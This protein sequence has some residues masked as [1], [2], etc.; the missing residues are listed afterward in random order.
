[1]DRKGQILNET[2]KVVNLTDELVA[3]QKTSNALGEEDILTHALGGKDRPRIV[4][5]VGKYVTKK[6]YFHTPTQPKPNQKDDDKAL[7]EE[8]GRMAQKVKIGNDDKQLVCMTLEKM[9]V[10]T[11]CKLPF[12]MKEHVVTWGTIFD[13]KVEGDN[14][15]VAID[16]VVDGDYA[17]SIPTKKGFYK[18]S[19]KVGLHIWWPRHLAITDNIKV[20]SRKFTKDMATFTPTPIQT[21]SVA[22]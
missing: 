5:D 7:S 21:A 15:K 3:T 12:E 19:Q 8:R 1:M 14:V 20:E 11:P 18:M 22:L 13:S 9:K 6:K 17:I 4:R 10:E 2:K 16:V